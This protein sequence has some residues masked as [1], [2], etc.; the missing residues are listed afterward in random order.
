MST[1][2]LKIA[3]PKSVVEAM[4][5]ELENE[6]FDGVQLEDVAEERNDP[7]ESKPLGLEPLV[8]FVVIVSGHLSASLIHDWIKK[9]GDKF[10]SVSVSILNKLGL[11]ERSDEGRP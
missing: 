3:G 1:E 6:R 7:L 8:Y 10:K 2:Q 11:K 4:R 5:R 9:R